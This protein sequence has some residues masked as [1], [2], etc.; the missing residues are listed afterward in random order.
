[1]SE[2]F[3]CAECE[4]TFP[5][6]HTMWVNSFGDPV[7]TIVSHAPPSDGKVIRDS[8]TGEIIF[9]APKDRLRVVAPNTKETDRG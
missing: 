6:H 5:H 3:T 8:E 1:M 2:A 7:P 9:E 4:L